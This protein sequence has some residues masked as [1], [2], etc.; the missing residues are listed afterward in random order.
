MH[1]AGLRLA[2]LVKVLVAL[3]LITLLVLSPVTFAWWRF[4]GYPW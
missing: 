1:A 3:A 2:E 4:I